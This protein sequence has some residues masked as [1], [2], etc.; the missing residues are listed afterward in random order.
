MAKSGKPNGDELAL[1]TELVTD[2]KARN[3]SAD[4]LSFGYDD[5][6]VADLKNAVLRD[7]GLDEVDFDLALKSLQEKKLVKTGPWDLLE[8]PKIPG[9]TVLPIPRCR[10]ELVRLT[11]DGYAA[12]R[13]GGRAASN[14][15]PGTPSRVSFHNVSNATIAVGSHISQTVTYPDAAWFARAKAAIQETLGDPSTVARLT[16]QIDELQRA[17]E[18][19]T[20]FT[21]KAKVT[22]SMIANACQIAGIS[23]PAGFELLHRY[24]R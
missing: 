21:D 4:D 23:A 1:L 9:V 8:P 16:A 19:K 11:Q 15:Q 2:F 13:E 18:S 24:V 10:Y 14:R 5:V 7:S 20:N 12:A 17:A 22:L 3:L 6:K